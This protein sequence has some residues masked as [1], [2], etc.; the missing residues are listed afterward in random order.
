[1]NIQTSLLEVF[2]VGKLG[3]CFVL[4]IYEYMKDLLMNFNGVRSRSVDKS[5]SRSCA[6]D[7]IRVYANVRASNFPGRPA[8]P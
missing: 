4:S 7:V 3:V 1:M 2:A 8:G 5:V 6:S